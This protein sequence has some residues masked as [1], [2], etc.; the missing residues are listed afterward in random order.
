LRLN[1]L[2][3]ALTGQEDRD[4]GL[5]RY[6]ALMARLG[7]TAE[8]HFVHVA[9]AGSAPHEELASSLTALAS[10]H[11]SDAPL[12]MRRAVHVLRGPLIDAILS[13]AAEN[14]TALILVGHKPI[15]GRGEKR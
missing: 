3:G 13:F 12:G 14:H 10:R 9:G 7:G 4:A 8:V 6:A 1:S 11:F 15:T 5:L 2:R